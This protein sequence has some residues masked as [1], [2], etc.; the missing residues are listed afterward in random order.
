MELVESTGTKFYPR[1]ILQNNRYLAVIY[2][3]PHNQT[4]SS[5]CIAS[6]KAV[7]D[8]I[9]FL[10]PYPYLATDRLLPLANTLVATPLASLPQ[11][12]HSLSFS[13]I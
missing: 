6:S 11:H 4:E 3:V 9:T 8:I 10:T 13:V 5:S 12:Y 7:N 2:G 1:V